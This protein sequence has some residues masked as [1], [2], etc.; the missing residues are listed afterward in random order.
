MDFL[1]STQKFAQSF[2]CFV[3]LLSKRPNLEKIFSNFVCFSESADLVNFFIP[4]RYRNKSLRGSNY[5]FP[6]LKCKTVVNLTKPYLLSWKIA[7]YFYRIMNNTVSKACIISFHYVYLVCFF[8][9]IGYWT[10]VILLSLCTLHYGNTG[11]WFSIGGYK[12]GK[13]FA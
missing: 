6:T 1:R 5:V 3:H 9:V 11:C 8:M 2:P 13:I 4:N 10:P 7:T 12:I